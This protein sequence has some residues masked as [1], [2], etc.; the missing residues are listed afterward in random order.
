AEIGAG[1]EDQVISRRYRLQAAQNGFQEAC[2]AQL[3]VPRRQVLLERALV[4]ERQE[5]GLIRD[6]RGKRAESQKQIVPL[7]GA[8]LQVH[9]LLQDVAEQAAVLQV[10]VPLG[11]SQLV[12]DAAGNE[13]RRGNL[14]V[15]VLQVLARQG[16][17]IAKNGDVPE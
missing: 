2:E 8:H 15:R 3:L 11:R 12:T 14:R 16:S 5:P 13:G 7:H 4:V 9:F 10:E 17:L 6:A 1:V